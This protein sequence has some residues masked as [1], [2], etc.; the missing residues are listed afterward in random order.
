VDQREGAAEVSNSNRR[1]YMP[2]L[3][4]KRG[5]LEALHQTFPV[6]R[7]L[8]IPLLEV[9]DDTIDE[10]EE[11]SASG[12]GGP[13][14]TLLTQIQRAWG[15]DPLFVDLDAVA[16]ALRAAGGLHPLLRLFQGA[17]QLG[18][19]LTPVTGL[20]RAPAF[21]QAVAATI[22]ADGRGACIR[23]NPG[24]VVAATFAA[25]LRAL[26]ATL[27]CAPGQIDLLLDWEA[28]AETA[29]PQTAL[30]IAAVVPN[31]PSLAAWRSVTFAASSF[32]NTLSAAGVGRATITR[33]EWEAY[34][35]LLNTPPGG[36][37]L[38]FG[39]YGI[40]YPVY[41]SVPYAGAA[42]IRYTIND[43]W[44]I[45]RGRSV[46]GPRF[47]GYAQ[48]HALCQQLVRDPEY[49]GAAFSW[50]DGLIDRCAQQQVGTGNLTTWRSV[51]T[52]HHIALVA[53]QLASHRAPS[54]GAAPPPVGP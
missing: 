48:F 1:V 28:I 5:E 11:D 29:G 38:S 10:D 18:F 27:Q 13:Y 19:L 43:D 49:R 46:Q 14:G 3:K 45:Y 34:Q 42:A 12:Q 25:S 52:N 9:L 8:V 36:R 41:E 4:W 37:L 20:G 17:S 47:G 53:R 33:A 54:S 2:I 7:P 39:D 21:Q 6:D 26:L 50:G 30:A 22:A 40:A 15:T 35:L 51:G 44:L 16:P 31:L 32:P 24:D 23:V